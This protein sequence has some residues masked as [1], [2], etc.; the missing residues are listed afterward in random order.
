V[1][2]QVC[3]VYPEARL[4][5]C[6]S[7]PEKSKLQQL[8]SDLG[9][10]EAVTFAGNIDNDSIAELYQSADIMLNTSLAD[11]MPVSVLE[12]LACGVP[13]VSTNVGGVP[14]LVTH[15]KTALLAEPRDY[16]VMAERVLS[17]VSQ[18]ELAEALVRAGLDEIQN[19]T[20]TAVKQ[21]LLPVYNS[22]IE[23]ESESQ[24]GVLVFSTLF[25]STATPNAG[26]FIRER[27][28]RVA[29]HLPVTVVSP[30]PW[31]PGQGLVRRF[32]PYIR[33]KTQKQ[34]LQYGVT[35]YYPR[36]FSIPFVFKQL[37]GI[38]MAVGS[39]AL[40]RRL[41]KQKKYR[42]LDAHFAYPD[43][44]AATLLGRW[45]KL[46]VTITL[47]GTEVPH[48][49]DRWLRPYLVRALSWATRIF[50]VSE[51]L[52]QHA[53]A[54]GMEPDK[55]CVVANGVDTSKFYPV[56]R[57]E[58][59]HRLGIAADAS[60]LVSVGALV[61]RKGF[62]RVIEILPELVESNPNLHYLIIGGASAEG[63]IREQLEQQVN[64][65]GLDDRVHFLGVMSPTEIK[66]P[67]SAADVFVLATS[68]EGWANVFL[69]AMAC[70]LPVVTTDV[71]GNAEVV[72]KP[73]L[74]TI[75]P[76]GERG[77]LRDALRASLSREWDRD[78]IQAYAEENAWDN[79]I[80]SLT[81][82]LTAVAIADVPMKI[83]VEADLT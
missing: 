49:R 58:A 3:R 27:M 2:H 50:S 36:F 82:E 28:F 17:L 63:G 35:V 20:W 7:G 32:R 24:S 78:L 83:D 31:F 52:R 15:E 74:G 40:L 60:I 55:I 38:F 43:G 33:Q 9:I 42:L 26:L 1:L 59:R 48:S 69:E 62:H 39:Y 12:A 23:T 53:I 18:P 79:R 54:L 21:D 76:F 11:N 65:L 75:V 44:Y 71:G 73:E 6:G 10:G 30:R 56:D 81:R 67:L 19:Y 37:D 80:S 13:I 64:D 25:P 16:K 77:A 51:S 66:W 22:V 5:I 70:R 68:N 47:R 61:E 29:K 4:T 45:L 34:E 46:P 72:C 41:R 14:Y 57:Q 8:A